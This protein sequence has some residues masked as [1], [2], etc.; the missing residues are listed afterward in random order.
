MIMTAKIIVALAGG[1]LLTGVAVGLAFLLFQ[2]DRQDPAA[3]GAYAFRPLLLPGLALLWPVV[4]L[5][6]RF[7]PP[8]RA[9]VTVIWHK[10]AHRGIWAAMALFILVTLGLAASIRPTKLPEQPSLRIGLA[11][12]GFV[13]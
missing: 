1:Y 5:R 11:A 6:W 12:A 3:R 7:Q 4:L 8:A 13:V 2:I 10:R 9:A